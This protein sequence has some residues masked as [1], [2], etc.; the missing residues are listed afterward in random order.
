MSMTVANPQ[1]VHC[2]TSL[3]FLSS[4]LPTMEGHRM[5]MPVANAQ[6]VSCDTSS[7]FLSS[8]SSPP[9]MKEHPMSMPVANAQGSLQHILGIPFFQSA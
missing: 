2:D 9:K 8:S 6:P 4:S 5:R 3:A 7:A 1:P